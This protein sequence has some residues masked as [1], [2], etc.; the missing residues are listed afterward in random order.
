MLRY[1]IL[2]IKKWRK[3]AKAIQLLLKRRQLQIAKE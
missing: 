1:L 3:I 2:S